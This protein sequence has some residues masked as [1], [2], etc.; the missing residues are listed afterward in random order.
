M[1]ISIVIPC[2]NMEKYIEEALLS[3]IN[4]KYENLELIIVDGA[5]TDNTLAIISK[6]KKHISL[7]ISEK[8]KGQYNA[9]NKGMS[10]ATGDILAWLNADDVYFPWTLK[11]VS[12]FFNS[13]PNQE[14]ISGSTSVMSEDGIIN[15]LNGNIISK[16]TEY[17]KN[18]WFRSGLYGYLQQEG[19]F[20]TKALWKKSGGLNEDYK[21]AA[22]FELW[23]RFAKFSKLVSFGLP[24]AC[25]R[26]RDS[27]RSSM[28][29][30][31]YEN[32][33]S[34][35][36]E[37]LIKIS[38]IKSFISGYNLVSNILFRKL[39][40]SNGLIY[41]FSLSQKKW[42]LKIKYSSISTHS[43]SRLFFLK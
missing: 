15:G 26:K 32:E 37:K 7:L 29:K 33:V 19:M 22:D 36:C 21:L 20:W 3:I 42:L 12:I 25:F 39:S 40:F 2:Y 28:L 5:S 24:L 17:V 31:D 16:P 1:K 14:W 18:G 4:Q 43:W 38:F 41:Y 13:Y 30:T 11:K 27:S 9:I 23:T 8:D 35:I 10:Y 34:K 6:Y